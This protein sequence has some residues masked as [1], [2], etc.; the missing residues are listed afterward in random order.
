MHIDVFGIGNNKLDV[1]VYL[2]EPLG[3][4]RRLLFTGALLESWITTPLFR[5]GSG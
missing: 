1:G 5:L 3:T 2:S 4:S